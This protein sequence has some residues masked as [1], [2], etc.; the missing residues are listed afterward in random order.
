MTEDQAA[1]ILHRVGGLALMY[2]PELQLFDPGFDLAAE[3]DWCLQ[4][5]TDQTPADRDRLR[6]L[7]SLVVTDPTV[8]RQEFCAAL[9]MLDSAG[10]R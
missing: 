9:Y 6:D 10:R 7:V 3:V 4:S 8:H 2:D 5:L 1:E